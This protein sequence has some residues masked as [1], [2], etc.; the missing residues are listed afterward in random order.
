[1]HRRS[2]P[3]ERDQRDFLGVADTASAQ[4]FPALLISRAIA[5]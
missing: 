3:Y 2:C 1:M 4:D 5:A